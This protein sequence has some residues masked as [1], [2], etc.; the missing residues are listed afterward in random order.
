M[1]ALANDN[2]IGR[3]PFPLAPGGEPLHEMEL[4]S[5]ARGRMCVKKVIAEPGRQGPRGRRCVSVATAFQAVSSVE[6][7][8]NGR[9][10]LSFPLELSAWTIRRI[11]TLFVADHI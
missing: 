5:L 2:W 1:Y 7:D 3:M 4:K 8:T 9:G 10:C 11:A 6:L